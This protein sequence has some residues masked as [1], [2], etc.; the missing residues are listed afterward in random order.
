MEPVHPLE[1]RVKD[2][3][4]SNKQ[5]RD[6]LLKQGI[7]AEDYLS[8]LVSYATEG[9]RCLRLRKEIKMEQIISELHTQ[10]KAGTD[11]SDEDPEHTPSVYSEPE[12]HPLFSDLCLVDRELKINNMKSFK[13]GDIVGIEASSAIIIKCLGINKDSKVLDM[14][15]SPGAKLMYISDLLK[16]F[17]AVD[18]HKNVVGCDISYHRSQICKSLLSKHQHPQVT[19]HRGDSTR[20]DEILSIQPGDR[21]EP[22]KV[23]V[24]VECTHEGSLKHILKFIVNS[25][26]KSKHELAE[27]IDQ[28]ITDQ[29]NKVLV[30]GQNSSQVVKTQNSGAMQPVK[31]SNKEKKRRAAQQLKLQQERKDTDKYFSAQE[32]HMDWGV[33]AFVDRVL[34]EKKL[35]VLSQLQTDLLLAAMRVCAVGGEIIYSTCSLMRSQNE[36]IL[37]KAFAANEPIKS[38][39]FQLADSLEHLG[40]EARTRLLTD[41]KYGVKPGMM[42]GTYYIQPN[43]YST[44][45]MFVSRILKLLDP[46]INAA[47]TNTD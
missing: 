29:P 47:P 42:T 8:L 25:E 31:L 2:F 18:Y 46:C 37:T 15:C 1:A 21:F 7:P 40:T 23:L 22:N 34:D 39:V 38:V 11:S 17:G 32:K 14:C 19:V 26:N 43:R 3:I 20:I 24:D 30:T 13:D 44:G 33:E 4:E 12:Y 36:D 6:Y 5:F 41:P 45:G 28:K 27:Q 16:G 9:R 10:N 35:L